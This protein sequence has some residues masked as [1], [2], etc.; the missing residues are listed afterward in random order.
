MIYKSDKCIYNHN[1]KQFISFAEIDDALT[2]ASDAQ[3][4]YRF[5]SNLSSNAD[6]N[7]FAYAYSD[8]KSK[9]KNLFKR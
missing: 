5:L 3:A 8:N 1:A 9:I 4:K 2:K 6:K 7:R